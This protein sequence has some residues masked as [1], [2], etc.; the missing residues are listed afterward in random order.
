MNI[1]LIDADL[2]IDHYDQLQ[3]A[4]VIANNTNET[5]KVIIDEY[6]GDYMEI[7]ENWLKA[8]ITK[9]G[10]YTGDIKEPSIILTDYLHG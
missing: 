7:E 6:V 10:I 5:R 3:A 9:L 2:P 4:I 8:K 1:Y